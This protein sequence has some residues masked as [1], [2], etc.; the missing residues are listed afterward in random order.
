MR[1]ALYLGLS[2][3]MSSPHK[4]NVTFWDMA[5]KPNNGYASK[6]TDKNKKS[7]SL[8][9]KKWHVTA[10]AGIGCAIC[11]MTCLLDMAFLASGILPFLAVAGAHFWHTIIYKGS[12][13]NEISH[14][15][16]CASVLGEVL[17]GTTVTGFGNRT[18]IHLLV[19]ILT[20]IILGQEPTLIMYAGSRLFLWSCLPWFPEVLRA[21]MLYVS[22]L[23]GVI[24]AKY[25][26]SVFISNLVAELKMTTT[27]RRRRTSTNT[28]Y[29]IY[30]IRRTSLPALGGSNKSVHGAFGYQVRH[31]LHSII[32]NYDS[33]NLNFRIGQ[34][35]LLKKKIR[36]GL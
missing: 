35:L 33:C 34:S 2:R 8:S 29:N 30:K 17:G 12:L 25:V 3:V 15:L 4:L 28:L 18:V 1:P 32:L 23:G 24:A 13:S 14:G 21:I 16:F 7:N 20:G 22:A 11:L 5:D 27:P 9:N 36:E 6:I 19:L 10:Y 26:E 31:C